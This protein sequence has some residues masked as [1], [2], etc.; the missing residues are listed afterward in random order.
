M[1]I[2]SL[3]LLAHTTFAS[4]ETQLFDYQALMDIDA[5]AKQ[6]LT[7]KTGIKNQ[8]EAMLVYFKTESISNS[9]EFKELRL[10]IQSY[11][12]STFLEIELFRPEKLFYDKWGENIKFVI[13]LRKKYAANLHISK[14]TTQLLFANLYFF[15]DQIRF[16][17][18][19]A[20]LKHLNLVSTNRRVFTLINS[21]NSRGRFGPDRDWVPYVQEM[22]TAVYILSIVANP[23][24][25][26][27]DYNKY[28]AND[29]YT[30]Y[31][32][33]LME[34]SEYEIPA[35]SLYESI[36]NSKQKSSLP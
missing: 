33:S 5:R 35:K 21:V 20:E 17:K 31:L 29:L 27:L 2:I 4:A 7:E 8:D 24:E 14:I 28:A 23:E 36:I 13:E 11:L 25:G 15:F 26:N 19:G 3:F 10:V 6:V 32:F 9:E 18:E 1:L 12:R 30:Y 22:K 34:F 16:F